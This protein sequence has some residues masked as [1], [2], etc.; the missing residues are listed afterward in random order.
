MRRWESARIDLLSNTK[1]SHRFGMQGAVSSLEPNEVCP[2]D[3]RWRGPG[4][5][6]LGVL[7]PLVP[8][9]GISGTGMC[10]VGKGGALPLP[11]GAM[12]TCH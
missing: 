9:E 5:G 4:Q 11:A 1:C 6:C 2:R 3:F 10:W 12:F 8:A 7:E